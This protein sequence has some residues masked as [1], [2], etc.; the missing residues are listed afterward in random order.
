VLAAIAAAYLFFRGLRG[1]CYIYEGLKMN[2]AI[3]AHPSYE[4][5]QNH[6]KG[7]NFRPM[8]YSSTDQLE[9]RLS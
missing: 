3:P 6:P 9:R 7:N 2:T 4:E 8:A 5:T 1:F